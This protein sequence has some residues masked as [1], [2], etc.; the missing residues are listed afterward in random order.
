MKQVGLDQAFCVSPHQMQVRSCITRVSCHR[1]GSPSWAHVNNATSSA[2]SLHCTDM[3]GGRHLMC[4]S[5]IKIPENLI[6]QR[7]LLV[8]N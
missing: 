6:N 8:Y 5:A 1:L 3:G 7:G 2:T 4:T